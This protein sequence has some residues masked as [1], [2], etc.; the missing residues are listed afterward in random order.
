MSKWEWKSGSSTEY[1]YNLFNRL[2]LSTPIV[3]H[4]LWQ[5]LY[6]R[7]FTL[8]WLSICL[9]V[10]ANSASFVDGAVHTQP[11]Q[12]IHLSLSCTPVRMHSSERLSE[13]D[14]PLNKPLLRM[15]VRSL[16]EED[17][18]YFENIYCHSFSIQ[19]KVICL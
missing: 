14:R 8:R 4:S 17:I 1:S 18:Q 11:N 12:L 15:N 10:R 16:S 5:F 13:E 7:S 6:I 2:C 9:F 19:Y 3:I